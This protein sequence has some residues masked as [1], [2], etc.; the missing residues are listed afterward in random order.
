LCNNE[1]ELYKLQQI[2]TL[3]KLFP[4]NFQHFKL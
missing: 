3:E 4:N 1:A 2:S